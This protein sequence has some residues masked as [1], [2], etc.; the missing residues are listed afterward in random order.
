MPPAWYPH[1]GS[2]LKNRRLLG[3]E[4][5]NGRDLSYS[6]LGGRVTRVKQC[7]L[8]SG[9]TWP[10]HCGSAIYSG[11]LHPKQQLNLFASIQKT[12]FISWCRL[13]GIKT[14]WGLGH[15]YLFFEKN[16]ILFLGCYSPPLPE[17]QIRTYILHLTQLDILHLTQLHYTTTQTSNILHWDT[18]HLHNS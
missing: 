18:L 17:R 6:L 14:L 7:A 8:T 15:N 16:T 11:V 12:K 13:P 5:V 2:F 1:L 10:N 3:F 4:Y 9:H